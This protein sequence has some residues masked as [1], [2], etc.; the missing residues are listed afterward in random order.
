M[1]LP[2]SIREADGDVASYLILTWQA[3]RPRWSRQF[4]V[5]LAMTSKEIIVLFALGIAVGIIAAL[6]A[7]LL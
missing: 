3:T 2:L 7:Y 4:G 6:I 1:V 5:M